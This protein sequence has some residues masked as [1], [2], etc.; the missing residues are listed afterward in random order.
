[1]ETTKTNNP[2]SVNPLA[3][4]G[5][6]CKREFRDWLTRNFADRRERNS[7]YSLRA[8]AK[9]LGM[10]ASSL[11]QIM[12]GKRPVSKKTMLSICERLDTSLS[13]LKKFGLV[14]D[15]QKSEIEFHL[16]QVDS[17][18]AISNPI[19]YA[20]LELTFVKNFESRVDWIAR[21]LGTTADIA[22]EA[23]ER[24]L[25]LGLLVEDSGALRKVQKHISSGNPA[26]VST[27][28]REHQRQVIQ[29]SLEAIN[30]CVPSEK[31]IT[32]MTFAIDVNR[33]PEARSY[34]QTFRREMCQFLEGGE[35]TRVYNLAI[36]LYPISKEHE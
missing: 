25:R 12:N 29:K 7:R 20:I 18:E 24:L 16:L 1:M 34:I 31:D 35:P 10:E 13:D 6:I 19:H 15:G 36:Q 27:A 33:L 28:H 22:R 4:Q 3:Y 23:M 30:N 32:S 11:S 17:F 8:F 5:E 26:A 21:Q 9:S 2:V 14:D